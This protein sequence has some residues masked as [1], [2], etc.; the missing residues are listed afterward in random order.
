MRP[1]LRQ[2]LRRFRG[3]REISDYRQWR[4]QYGSISPD[5]LR[6]IYDYHENQQG[7]KLSSER[8]LPFDQEGQAV[9]WITYPAADYLAQLDF[10]NCRV[11]EYGSGNSSQFWASRCLSL[12][13]VESDAAWL[14]HCQ[15]SILPN[16]Q[17]IHATDE[18]TY[19]KSIAAFK[20]PFDVIIIDGDF[21]PAC[22]AVAVQQLASRGMIL[23]D[24]SDWFPNTLTF[25]ASHG[26]TQI[27][28]VGPGPINNYLWCTSIF[29]NRD[30]ALPRLRPNGQILM[31]G[32]LGHT[33]DGEV[34]P[35]AAI[36]TA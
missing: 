32:G 19:S 22:A 10:S 13:S 30:F 3:F 28:F 16:Q 36:H 23:F 15:K 1:K 18:A 33:L 35:V 26:L 7:G 31:H 5:R 34:R 11:F 9:P 24:N 4:R 29:L 14:A 17:M 25:L 12:V 27:D 21:R 2:M 20:T 6:W 8:K